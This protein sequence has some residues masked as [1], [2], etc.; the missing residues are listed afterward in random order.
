M[1]LEGIHL[2]NSF[3]YTKPQSFEIEEPEEKKMESFR[4]L[5]RRSSNQ[6]VKELS[7]FYILDKA[8]LS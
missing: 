2:A 6:D 3:T 7:I 5:A 1:H 8:M 4:I